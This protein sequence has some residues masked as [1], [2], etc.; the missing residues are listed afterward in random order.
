MDDVGKW[1]GEQS[2]NILSF[3]GGVIV[4]FVFYW[5]SRRPKRFGWQMISATRIVSAKGR[6]LP[7]VVVYDGQEVSSPNIAAIRVGNSGKSEITVEDYDGPVRITFGQSKVLACDISER[8]HGRITASVTKEPP[9]SVVFSPTLLNPGEWLDLQIITDGPLEIPKVDARIAGQTSPVGDVAK[10]QAKSW[11]P[12]LYAG[13]AVGLGIPIVISIFFIDQARGWIVP[14]VS[15]GLVVTFM[16]AI[17]MS[18][19]PGWA[20]QP[21]TKKAHKK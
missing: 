17:Q 21:S 2:G 12:V 11:L 1:L 13:L 4:S 18:R 9:S 19:T 14:L 16:A 15:I 20:K 7:L 10:A 8:L 5:I 3:V 6:S